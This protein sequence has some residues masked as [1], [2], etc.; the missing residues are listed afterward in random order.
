MRSNSWSASHLIFVGFQQ[1][2]SQKKINKKLHQFLILHGDERL[3]LFNHLKNTSNTVSDENF[4]KTFDA[5]VPSANLIISQTTSAKNN[6][7]DNNDS[8]DNYARL[9]HQE[10]AIKPFTE[11]YPAN[12]QECCI[13]SSITSTY[14]HERNEIPESPSLEEVT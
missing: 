12:E 2:F 1:K 4:N 11:I 3:C 8:N 9:L 7:N 14:V 13:Y 6:N 5:T 10:T